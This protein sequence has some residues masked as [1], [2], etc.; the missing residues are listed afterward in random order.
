MYTS[1][2]NM[3]VNLF[4]VTNYAGPKIFSLSSRILTF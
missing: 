3:S 4:L 2:H 1:K